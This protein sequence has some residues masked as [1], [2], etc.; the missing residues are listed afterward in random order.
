MR[1]ARR[2][3]WIVATMVLVLVAAPVL[4]ASVTITGEVNDN[5]QVVADDQIYEIADT[6]EGNELAENHISEKVEVVGSVQDN[7]DL[8]IL[9]VVSYK[10]LSD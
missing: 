8:K 1:L 5:Y 3:K 2:V 6:P 10:I 9:T 7:E 4:A